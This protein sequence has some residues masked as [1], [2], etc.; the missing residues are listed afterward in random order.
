[1]L[2]ENVQEVV[3]QPEIVWRSVASGYLSHQVPTNLVH[4]LNLIL[5]HFSG[6][7]KSV[8]LAS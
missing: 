4:A 3:G 1:M 6:E 2:D 8:K 7:T 5:N